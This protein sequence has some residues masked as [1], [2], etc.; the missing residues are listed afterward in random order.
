MTTLERIT[1][2]A[3]RRS[4]PVTTLMLTLGILWPPPEAAALS[5]ATPSHP[6]LSDAAAVAAFLDDLMARKM[7]EHQIP[8]AALAVVKDGEMLDRENGVRAVINLVFLTTALPAAFTV[9]RVSRFPAV[10]FDGPLPPLLLAAL[11]LPWVSLAL[12]VLQAAAVVSAWRFGWWTSAWLVRYGLLTLANGG[13]LLYL[14]FWN[15][16]GLRL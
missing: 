16:L 12:T 9:G 2:A 11:A 13:F 14:R 3:N 10:A 7:A 5:R 15:L 8:G 6:S 4:R 1:R